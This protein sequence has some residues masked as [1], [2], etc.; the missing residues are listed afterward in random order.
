MFRMDLVASV[1][2][3]WVALWRQ[4]S[5]NVEFIE[6]CIE[7]LRRREW[8]ER[9]EETCGDE[10]IIFYELDHYSTLT[11]QVQWVTMDL[12]Y[13]VAFVETSFCSAAKSTANAKDPVSVQWP[14]IEVEC[15]S[16]PQSCLLL[17]P[18][19]ICISPTYICKNVG[20]PP[21]L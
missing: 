12:P 3:S 13:V 17:C 1:Q 15:E 18:K 20:F 5:I 16:E 6:S 7:Y 14:R 21:P 4:D 8:F 19:G 2:Q 9:L 10:R 11:A